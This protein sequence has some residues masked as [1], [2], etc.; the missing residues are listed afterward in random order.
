M[1][2]ALIT[3]VV[4]VAVAVY[5]VRR[6]RKTISDFTP[7]EFTFD[8]AVRGMDGDKPTTIVMDGN[9]KVVETLGAATSG[10]ATSASEGVNE[11]S[12]IAEKKPRKPRAKKEP[13][14]KQD[15]AAKNRKP[16]AKKGDDTIKIVKV[17]KAKRVVKPGV[18]K[19]NITR[20]KTAKVAETAKGSS[21]KK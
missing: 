1:L 3:L 10:V 18:K 8:S 2:I 4:V 21:K 13:A 20:K 12:V 7:Q 14:P 5:V 17:P 11:V 19:V 15:T 9:D 6:I 16:L